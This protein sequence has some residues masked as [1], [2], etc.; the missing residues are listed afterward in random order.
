MDCRRPTVRVV[1][2]SI[3]LYTPQGTPRSM[4]PCLSNVLFRGSTL[5]AR[6]NPNSVL[7]GRVIPRQPLPCVRVSRDWTWARAGEIEVTVLFPPRSQLRPGM[8][9]PGRLAEKLESH[10]GVELPTVKTLT[11]DLNILDI[12]LAK[13]AGRP[14]LD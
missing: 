11:T 13:Q 4:A 3:R 12:M 14:M 8:P 5:R 1:V 7:S 6:D 10:T 2:A 9:P